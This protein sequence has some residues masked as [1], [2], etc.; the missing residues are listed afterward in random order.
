MKILK[1]KFRNI[2]SLAGDWEIDFTQPEFTENGLFAITGKTGSGK[3]SILDAISLALYGKTPRVEVT[4]NNNHVMTRG[5]SD[6][7][8][9]IVFEVESKIWKSRWQQERAKRKA[10]GNLKQVERAIADENDRIV[11]DKISIKRGKKNED[12]KTVNEKIVEIIGLTFEQFTKVILL[13]QGD[14]VAFLQANKSDKGELLEQITGTEIYGVISKKVFDRNKI[15]NQKLENINIELGTIKILSNEEIQNLQNEISE[16][17]KEKILIDNELQIIENVKKSLKDLSDL[18]KQMNDS[19]AKLPELIK[20]AEEAKAIFEKAEQEVIAT[21]QEHEKFAP[22]FLKVRELNT[23]IA[24]KDKALCTVLQTISELEKT[25][26]NLAQIFENKKKKLIETENSLQQ[27]QTWATINAKYELLLEQFAAIENQHFELNNLLLDFNTK[28]IEFENAKKDLVT[29]IS[30]NKKTLAFFT[31]KE[32]ILHDKEEELKIKKVELSEILSGKELNVYQ[33]EKENITNLGIHIKNLV[34]VEKEI[35]E[36]RTEI[37]KNK[38]FIVSSENLEKELF[39]KKLNNKTNAENIKKQIDLLAE[40]IKLTKIIQNLD[41]YRKSLEDGKPCPLCGS[42][43]HPYALGNEPKI[44]E[45]ESELENIKKQEQ[46]LTN[47]VQQDEKTL[48]RLISDRDNILINNEK[49]EKKLLENTKKRDVILNE[50]KTM[51]PDFSIPVGENKIDLLEEIQKQKQNEYKQITYIILN[52]TESEKLLKKIQDKEIPHLQQEKQIAEKEKTD[53]ETNRKLS[54]QNLEN[55]I[56]LLEDSDKKYKEKN[57]ELLKI[58]AK[59]DV[60]NIETLKKCLSDWNKNKALIEE[61]KEQINKLENALALTNAEIENNQ[62]QFSNKTLEKQGIETEKQTFSTERYDLFGDKRVEEEEKQLK[63]LLDKSEALKVNA[64]KSKITIDTEL[65]KNQVIITEKEKE[66]T[67]KQTKNSTEKTVEDLQTEYD[68]KRQQSDDFSQKIGAKKQELKANNENL[69]KNRKKLLEKEKQQQISDQWKRLDLLIGS[70]DGKKYR[71]FAQTLTF[72]NLIMLA[73]RQ[74]RKMTERYILKRTDDWQNPF[75]LSVIDKFQNS[76]ERTAQNL[77]G[78]EKFIVSLALALGLANMASKNMKIEMMFID[79]GFGTLDSD[80]LNVA[81]TALS[82]LQKEG[83]LIGVI[84]HLT[85]LKERI[86]THIEVIPK[87]DGRS[88][89]EIVY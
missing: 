5:T 46:E 78:G 35:T 85:E 88:K 71:N 2:N 1:L 13:A 24:E 74:L 84:S 53:A 64:E 70:A 69:E 48:T 40:T 38:S 82:N 44:G 87:G 12:E 41:E 50:I 51:K 17:E 63:E 68:E 65:A 42:I 39:K 43:E 81:I 14:F 72:E 47:I 21:K 56:K 10:D 31:E 49:T 9:E 60:E 7:Y 86:T 8:A 61:Q 58:F 19:K 11:A 76:D 26:N 15:E 57:T 67:E 20:N 66:L 3:S 79:E 54:E 22:I 34:G 6:C 4:G 30:I 16:F 77:S 28:N 80:Y 75:E 36:N 89:L 83:K 25:K 23:K 45:K 37:E 29:K 62:K 18:Q 55:K 73:N 32:K 52:A 27:Q 59:Y 33:E